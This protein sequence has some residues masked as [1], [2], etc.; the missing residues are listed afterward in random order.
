M[1]YREIG[2]TGKKASVLG[3]GAMRLP[4]TGFGSDK[5]VKEDESIKMIL[6]AFELGVN[7]ID[8]AYPY[9]SNQSE[10]TVG[11]ALNAWKKILAGSNHEKS[12]PEIKKSIFPPNSLHGSLVKKMIFAFF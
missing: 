7:I 2:K 12:A 1:E 3:F 8:T 9:C 5:K 11:K 10:K 6:R 4:M